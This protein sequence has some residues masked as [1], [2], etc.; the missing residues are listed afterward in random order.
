MRVR[1]ALVDARALGASMVE[2]LD[3][4]R[5]GV[6]QLDRRGRLVAAN[7]AAR[8]LLLEGDRLTDRDGVLRAT[9]P[10]EDADLQGLVAQA[11]PFLG[12]PGAS[13]SMQLSGADCLPRLALHVSP[14]HEAGEA[15]GRGRI[16]ALVLA[17]D[18]AWRWAHRPGAGGGS[19]SA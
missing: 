6:F 10:A 4:V 7:E 19:R 9:L 18:P 17:V 12:G 14:A 15:P 1:A 16:G 13:G 2:L 5:T 8:A 11:L 3:N